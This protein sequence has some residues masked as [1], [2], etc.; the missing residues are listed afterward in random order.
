MGK[1]TIHRTLNWLLKAYYSKV[2]KRLKARVFPM[3]SYEKDEAIEAKT[4]NQLA[5][6]YFSINERAA[7]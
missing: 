6:H 3:K 1:A 5:M 7:E 2:N 4:L